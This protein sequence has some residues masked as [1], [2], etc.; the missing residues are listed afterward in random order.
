MTEMASEIKNVINSG[1]ASN[2]SN[3][4]LEAYGNTLKSLFDIKKE[5]FNSDVVRMYSTSLDSGLFPAN[6]Y[7]FFLKG[8]ETL[9]VPIQIMARPIQAYPNFPDLMQKFDWNV[10]CYGYF[11]KA[12]YDNS[13]LV[14]GRQM[15]V[16]NL[17]DLTDYT[18]N[19]LTNKF[20][21]IK[22]ITDAQTLV[23][24][25]DTVQQRGYKFYSRFKMV[26]SKDSNFFLSQMMLLSYKLMNHALSSS[27][28]DEDLLEIFEDRKEFLIK[29]NGGADMA[30]PF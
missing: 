4:M 8:D 15:R 3:K 1:N 2:T 25:I 6:T 12:F 24:T 27:I 20:K 19:K 16:E 10:C 9:G 26:M 28:I 5:K 30:N 23:S 21:N 17:L 22:S 18:V 29:N 11:D 14:S 13:S 7:K